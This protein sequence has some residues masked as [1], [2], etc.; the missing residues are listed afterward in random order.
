MPSPNTGQRGSRYLDPEILSELG[1]LDV[2]VRQ[3]VEGMRVGMHRSHLRGFSTD[4]T[5]HRPYVPGDE[6]R[7][8]DW[9]LY[10]RTGRYYIK[11]F[12]AET[13]FTANLLLDAS[14][15]MRYASGK[16]SKLEYAKYMAASLA[17]LI[18]DQHDSVGAGVFDG[19][20]QEY[21][22]PTSSKAV[23]SRLSHALEQA[24]SKPRT[25]VAAMLHEFARRMSR[26][27]VVILFSDLFDHTEAFIQ[28]LSHLRFRGHT[29]IVFHIMDPYELEFP[30]QGMRR[31][32][33]M[34]NE[35]ETITHASRIR[36]SYL[37]E[38]EGFIN[39]IKR[40]CAKLLVDYVL[41]NTRQPVETAI[42]SYLV[43]CSMART[44]R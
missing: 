29:V 41:V 42:A 24:Q 15:S 30:L 25:D 38:V 14:V 8:I 32:Q 17:Y 12:Q 6:T 18:V 2:V 34:E 1:P 16:I 4:F 39:Q 7:R 33:G 40:A 37:A 9:K 5:A 26:R 36:A 22:E 10:A 44:M 43:Q 3:I 35:G 31:F 23:L 28:G 20:L 13:N 19:E 21:I 11:L 27:G